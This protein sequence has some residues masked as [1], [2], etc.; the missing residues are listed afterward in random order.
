MQKIRNIGVG[1]AS[2]RRV[3]QWALDDGMSV[4]GVV[5]AAIAQY[6]SPSEAARLAR[7]CER[8]LPAVGRVAR[9]VAVAAERNGDRHWEP[10]ESA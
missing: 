7:E 9:S 2:W 1:E 10:D 3:K 8:T 5:E 6:L 4:R